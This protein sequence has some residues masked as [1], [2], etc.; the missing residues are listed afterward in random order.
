MIE[1]IENSIQLVIALGCTVTA[2]YRGIRVKR[3]EW[4]LMALFSGSYFL[5]DLYWLLFLLFYGETPDFS[6]IPD[7]SWYAGF[8][9][10]LI[11]L[12]Q[13]REGF[14]T[15]RKKILWLVPVF[16]VSMCAFYMQWGSYI[17]NIIYAAL[18]TLILLK[19]VDGELTVREGTE[20][21]NYH[22]LFRMTMFFCAMEYC[23]WTA[24]C[25]FEGDSL[26][27]PYYW[28]DILL[29]VSLI[30]FIRAVRRAV[31]G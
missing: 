28:F 27:N 26:R 3:R 19:A 31:D 9:F 4:V 1:I 18:L 8:L 20:Q 16:T 30:G 11:L 13:F 7:M 21:K 24:S 2:V 12:L 29:T 10:L 14:Q 25:F 15:S 22:M 23:M 17:S 5:G 6:Y